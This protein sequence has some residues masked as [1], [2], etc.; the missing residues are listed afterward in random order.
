MATPV[1]ITMGTVKGDVHDAAPPRRRSE[2]RDVDLVRRTLI[3]LGI[4]AL[5]YAVCLL[6]G[7]LLLAFG[8]VL[9]A[10]LLHALADVLT[11]RTPIPER[12]SLLAAGL[13]IL[14]LLLGIAFL[15]GTTILG[16]LVGLAGQLPGALDGF[17]ERFGIGPVS[18]RLSELATWRGGPG[19]GFVGRVASL[20]ST[21]LGALV[22]TILVLVAGSFIAVSPRV[23]RAGMVKLFP[24]GAHPSVEGALDASGRVLKLWLGATLISMT[25]V[26]VTAYLALWVIGV[27]S[28]V[29]LA[30][31][32]GLANFIPFIGGIIGAAP[33]VL[34][35]LTV[36]LDAALYTALAFVA[37]QQV[38]NNVVFPL[39][40]SEVLS[41]PPALGLFAIVATGVLFGPL[42]LLFGFPLTVVALVLVKKLY[43]RETLGEETTVPGEDD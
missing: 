31:L 22:D 4:A 3:V 26:V 8:S 33:A 40:G 14:L 15:F 17:T 13:L 41:V 9:V 5:A 29:G 6:S 2:M 7:V 18:S 38:E 39:V 24:K 23:Y 30:L 21:V 37:I 42:G 11:R 27:P 28:P 32:A 34:L 25:F 36:G 20:G 19:G 16:Q 1:E 10:V 35:A 12:W 43:V